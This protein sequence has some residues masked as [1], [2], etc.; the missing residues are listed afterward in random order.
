MEITEDHV[1]AFLHYGVRILLAISL[2]GLAFAIYAM[3]MGW[4]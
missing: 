4:S 3:A 1:D 2:V